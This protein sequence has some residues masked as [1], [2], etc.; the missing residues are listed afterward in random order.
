M[1]LDINEI[2]VENVTMVDNSGLPNFITFNSWPLWIDIDPYHEDQV[3]NYDLNVTVTTYNYGYE[4]L[5]KQI[6]GDVEVIVTNY[7]PCFLSWFDDRV[8]RIGEFEEH[9]I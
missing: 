8:M 5:T 7:K 1:A 3:G 6:A 9:R 2:P 4:R